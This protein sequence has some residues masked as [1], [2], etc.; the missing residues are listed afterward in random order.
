MTGQAIGY[1]RTSTA[2][3]R[4]GLEDQISELKMAGCT[5]I[6]HE[7]IG[8]GYKSRPELIQALEYVRAGDTFVV[9]KPDRLARSVRHLME[10]RDQLDN[11]KVS[12]RVLSMGLDTG[13]ATG[14]L[15]LS[16][17]ASVAQFERDIML[18]RQKVGIAKAKAE[19]KYKGRPNSISREAVLKRLEQKQ[20]PTVIAADLGIGRDSVYRI[21]KELSSSDA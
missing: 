20:S 6:F 10:I 19:G 3:Q 16:V 2:D 14:K 8:G 7:Q 17:L 11:E 5:R 12:L 21:K 15:M 9:T 13:N 1:T 18:E 4:A